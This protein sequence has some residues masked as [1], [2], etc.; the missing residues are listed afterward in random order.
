MLQGLL[1][2]PQMMQSIMGMLGNLKLPNQD[3]EESNATNEAPK[4]SSSKD[5]NDN[6]A[7]PSFLSYAENSQSEKQHRN[8][9]INDLHPCQ[10]DRKKLLLALK[11]FMGKERR[12]KIDFILNILSLLDVAQSLGFTNFKI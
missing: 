10:A 8:S 2:N 3:S 12:D 1:E 4:Q 9:N 7:I 6:E 11:P 5:N